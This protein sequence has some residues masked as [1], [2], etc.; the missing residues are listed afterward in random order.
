MAYIKQRGNKW[1]YSVSMGINPVTKKQIQITKSGFHT[2]KEAQEAADKLEFKLK[3]ER[4]RMTTQRNTF[5][6]VAEDWLSIYEQA[7]KP[8]TLNIRKKALKKALPIWGN[9]KIDTINYRTY[10]SL[11]TNLSAKHSKNYVESIHD[12]LSLVFKFAKRENL[13]FDTPCQNVVFKKEYID[14]DDGLENFLEHD[15]LKEFLELANK[16]KHND[17]YI[18]F[19]TL[20]LTGLRIGE[21]MALRWQDVNLDGKLISVR[22]TLY[23]PNNNENEFLLTA[24]KTKKSK[25]VIQMADKL[26]EELIAYKD[27]VDTNFKKQTGSNFV[28]FK[29]HYKPLTNTYVRNRLVSLRRKWDYEKNITLHSFRHTFASLLIEDGFSILDVSNLLGHSDTTIT[30]KIYTHITQPMKLELQ[31]SLSRFARKL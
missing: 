12:T 1:G 19:L 23:N 13:I 18:I 16:S 24:T 5:S 11:I 22:H 10:Q 3:T 21:L 4:G 17:D 8:A 6:E 30:T 7:V 27:Y 9:S 2:R 14:V 20:S 28:F 26:Q 29:G 31:T 15:K 25:R